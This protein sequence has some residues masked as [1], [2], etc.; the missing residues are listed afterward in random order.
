MKNKLEVLSP[1]GDLERLYAAIQYGADAIYL[2]GTDFGM[3]TSTN[4]FTFDEMKKGVDFAHENNVDV[5]LTCN[6]IPTNEEMDVLPEFL[7]NS[8]KSGVDAF[9]VADIGT[10]SLAKKHT[11]NME[12]HIST[13]AGIMNYSTANAMYDLG[14]N[15]IVLA[16]E[17]SLEDIKI[18]RDKTNPN[19][20]IEAFVHGAMCMAFSGRCLIS[21]YM[22]GRDANRGSCAQPCRWEYFLIDGRKPDIRYPIFEDEKGTHI[23]NAKD[24]CMIEYIDKIAD[25]GV[26]SLK[27]EG[28]AKSSYYVSVITNAYRLAVDQYYKDPKN[29]KLDNW[30]LDEVFKV[31][32][33]KYSTGFYF[34]K[35]SDSEYYENGGYSR[36]YDIIAVINQHK[37][38]YLECTQ[39]N[40]FCIGEK[41]EIMQPGKKPIEF[42]IQNIIDKDKN[43]SIDSACHATMKINIPFDVEEIISGSIIRR[44]K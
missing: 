9:I 29:F 33:R 27:I 1:V 43:L 15:R 30:V 23:L 17:L 28:R 44:Y 2:G 41:V 3:R 39:K 25:A 8:E 34:G 26:S 14:A 24:L 21:N 16:R 37:D 38:N 11:P 40:K 36:N 13:Q 18:I 32:H 6:T 4:N 42:I 19:I 12:I 35:Q 10:L 31:S 7:K 20:E 5:Y 22:L